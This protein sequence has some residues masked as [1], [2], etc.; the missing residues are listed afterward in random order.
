MGRTDGE[1]HQGLGLQHRRQAGR[2]QRGR[3]QTTC[4]DRETDG[5][6][7]HDRGVRHRPGRGCRADE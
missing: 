2:V 1:M 5:L 3:H 7:G 6:P 4:S